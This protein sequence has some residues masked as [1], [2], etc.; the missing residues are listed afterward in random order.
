MTEELNAVPA[1]PEMPETPATPEA[2]VEEE[3]APDAKADAKA[4]K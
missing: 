2:P 1:E 4:K 3:P